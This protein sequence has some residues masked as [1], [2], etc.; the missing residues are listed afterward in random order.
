[1][2]VAI[3]EAGC[4]HG[5]FHTQPLVVPELVFKSGLYSVRLFLDQ[6]LLEA[7]D[8]RQLVALCAIADAHVER[9]IRLNLLDCFEGYV[10]TDIEAACQQ[11]FPRQKPVE[12]LQD[13]NVLQFFPYLEQGLVNGGTLQIVDPHAGNAYLHYVSLMNQLVMMAT[14]V[15]HDACMPEHHKYMAHQMALLYQC[16]NQLQGETKPVRRIIEAQFEIIKQVTESDHPVFTLDMSDWFQEISWLCREQVKS[17]PEYMH[18][19][20]GDM[21]SIAKQG[22]R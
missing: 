18:L 14:Q 11:L 10:L 3:L 19:R 20:L 17:C 7:P 15:Y 21:M 5:L 12:V 4:A 1:M 8:I 16:L 13:L 2:G 6:P 22:L 9:A